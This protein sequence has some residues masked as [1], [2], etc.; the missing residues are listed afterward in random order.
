MKIFELC[1]G[2]AP[3]AESIALKDG[4]ELILMRD[5]SVEQYRA[6]IAAVEAAGFSYDSD[7]KEG[8]V[9]FSTYAKGGHVLLISYVPLDNATRVISEENT[10]IPP[11]ES[12]PQKLCA[13]L[14]TQ[15]KTPYLICDC[16]MSY[17]MRLCDGR[18]IIIDGGLGE[19]EETEYLLETM[20]KQNVQRIPPWGHPRRQ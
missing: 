19:Y 14:M 8:E 18:F 4:G 1:Q 5:S 16:G 12:N 2:I 13:P 17:L 3:L 20:E 11:R 6:V 10:V 15:L 9:L 7:R